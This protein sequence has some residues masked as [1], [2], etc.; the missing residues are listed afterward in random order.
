MVGVVIEVDALASTLRRAAHTRELAGARLAG[1][2]PR[3]SVATRAAVVGVAE[4][5]DAAC[6]AEDFA[7]TASD[8]ADAVVAGLIGG[9]AVIA[10]AAVLFV[11]LKARADAVTFRLPRAALK[12]TGA[13]AAI[14]AG[15][16][17]SAA[18]A[19]VSPGAGR[20]APCARGVSASGA[21][22]R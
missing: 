2:L 8:P 10:R 7:L 17:L 20:P 18:P 9:A 5:I 19:R 11:G 21:G 13:R 3:A 15:R 16:P 14:A 22:P 1:L 6:P 12:P 4:E